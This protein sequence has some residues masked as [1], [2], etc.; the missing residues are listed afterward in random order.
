MKKYI[1]AVVIVCFLS[2]WTVKPLFVRGFFPMHDDTQVGRVVAMGR[3]LRLGQFPVRFV[4]D[5][6]YGYGYPIFNFYA[7][8]PYYFGGILYA[9]GVSG[10]DA[11]KAM[12][13]IGIVGA[14]V[15]MLIV[16]A[17]RMGLSGALLAAI[18][19]VYAPYHA[20]QIYVRGA[21]G[22]FWSLLFLPILFDGVLRLHHASERKRGVLLAGAGIAGVIVSHTI[23]GYVTVF[24]YVL[25]GV[26]FF[27][28]SKI[29][30]TTAFN[31][32]TYLIALLLGLGLSSFFWLPALA[33]MSYTNV[34]GQI[35]VSAS[36]RDHF[37]CIGQLW[38]SLWG[39]GGSAPGCI[40]GLSFKLGKFP[41][42]LAVVSSLIWIAVYKKLSQSASMMI[43]TALSLFVISIFFMTPAS[44]WI[45]QI[46]PYFAY[47]Q[48]PWRFLTYTIV[49]LSILAGSI[50][51]HI[52]QPFMRWASVGVLVVAVILLQAKLFTPQYQYD[53]SKA[54][55]ET[56]S[57]LRYR[58]SKISDEYMPADFIRPDREEDVV[59]DTIHQSETLTVKTEIDTDTE[60]RFSL[61][62]DQDQQVLVYRAY[63]PGWVYW[64]NGKKQQLQLDHGRPVIMVPKGDSVVQARLT[65]TPVRFIANLM[66]VAS[67]I[68]V[69]AIYGKK[70]KKAI[71]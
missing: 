31:M 5:L 6:G 13:F 38:N 2:F 63:F 56:E 62:S 23:I 39:F 26:I 14:G 59:R 45:W 43:L 3:A 57:E 25:G 29:R 47:I 20:V 18:V 65:D 71:T 21:V 67:F 49:A 30:K 24:L 53:K 33:E 16:L 4:S 41:I 15:S 28:V 36:F 37:V 22:E 8:L 12:F 68:V 52:A 35:G 51:W 58:V 42:L 9:L 66:T 60:L 54:A 50:A 69:I 19:Y 46:L 34:A 10:L 48:Y 44:V 7:P 55:F 40:D 1:V 27:L 17:R 61:K 70:R 32:A 11:T 64:V